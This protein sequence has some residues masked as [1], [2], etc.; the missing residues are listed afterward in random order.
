MISFEVEETLGFFQVI[1]V[2]IHHVSRYISQ[3]AKS[4]LKVSK[5]Q[6][7]QYDQ[8]VA[9][10]STSYKAVGS[11]DVGSFVDGV[12][13]W[14][15]HWHEVSISCANADE[16][17]KQ[18][19]DLALGEEPSW[20]PEKL[21]EVNAAQSIYLPACEMLKQMDGVGL[22]N[23]NEIDAKAAERHTEEEPEPAP[24]FFW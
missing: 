3:D 10:C 4:I 20:T 23:D 19:K 9:N 18:N 5:V 21:A 17:F 12:G 1:G 6:E 16:M 14:L 15:Y 2:R 7:L 22:D 8:T 11:L 24:Y 13:K